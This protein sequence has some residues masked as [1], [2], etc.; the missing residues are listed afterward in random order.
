[1]KPIDKIMKSN[2]K[3]YF[4]KI[5][6]N[7]LYQLV[8]ILLNFY[9]FVINTAQYGGIITWPI[10]LLSIMFFMILEHQSSHRFTISSSPIA[11]SNSNSVNASL[12]FS[13]SKNLSSS[14]YKTR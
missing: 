7:K 2:G 1:M 9:E 8:Q 14:L 5:N 6:S 3:N 11:G 12:S 13:I 10:F 4:L